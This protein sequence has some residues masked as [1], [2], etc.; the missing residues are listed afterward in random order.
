MKSQKTISTTSLAQTNASV[1]ANSN[2]TDEFS[3]TQKQTTIPLS[4]V[5]NAGL[6]QAE[7]Q[8]Q[9]A[10]ARKARKAEQ[11]SRAKS[12]PPKEPKPLKLTIDIP[13]ERLAWMI[14]RFGLKRVMR[15][16]KAISDRREAFLD[17]DP[18]IRA[19]ATVKDGFLYVDC[20]QLNESQRNAVMACLGG[21]V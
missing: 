6:N 4:T 12:L 11:R 14:A 8:Q 7:N 13:E 3:L 10:A 19:A 15:S 21:A 17:T 2:C 18:A 9:Y 16:V 1:T 20:S 5:G